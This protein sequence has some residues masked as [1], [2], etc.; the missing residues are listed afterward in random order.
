MTARR[1]GS[2]PARVAEDSER[3][4]AAPAPGR[5]PAAGTARTDPASDASDAVAACILEGYAA[6]DRDFR[7]V[8]RWARRRFEARDWRGGQA[9]AA[10]RL[11]LYGSALA[12]TLRAVDRLAGGAGA[13]DPAVWRSA[14]ARFASDA[15]SRSDSEIARTFFNSVSRR[16]FDTVGVRPELEFVGDD[17]DVPPGP[18]GRPRGSRTAGAGAGAPPGGLGDRVA[19]EVAIDADALNPIVRAMLRALPFVE[20]WG[21]LERDVFRTA[22]ALARQ[23]R[24]DR[25][26]S[27][28]VAIEVL[29]ELLYRNKAAYL[30]GRVRNG[31]QIVPLVLA[32]LHDRRGVAVD[33]VL[34]DPAEV[35]IVFGFSR[36]YFH[37]ELGAP[38]AAVE[39][40]ASI[41]PLKRAHELYTSLGYHRHGKTELYRALLR[42][43]ERPEARFEKAEGTEGTVMS[44]F[45]LPSLNV[46]FKVIKDRFPPSKR[47]TREEVQRRYRQ[48][49]VRDRV[50]RLA[51]AQE[52]EHLELRRDRFAPGLLERLLEEAGGSVHVE[53]DRVV[54]EHLYTERRMTPLDLYLERADP[55]SARTAILDYGWAVRDLAAANIFPGDLL[56]KNFGVSRHGRVIFYDYDELTGLEECRFRALPAARRPED[57][58]ADEPWF[59]VAPGDVFPEEFPRFLAIPRTLRSLFLGHHGELFEPAF[60]REMQERQRVGDVVDFFPYPEERRLEPDS[61]RRALR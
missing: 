15:A 60:W 2:S 28:T 34:T 50:G 14:R 11:G 47:V 37:A 16:V 6:Y 52:F 30:V 44:V 40:L 9:D 48:V 57:E 59:H 7:R 5:V 20:L 22:T 17:F 24:E 51:D 21:H 54:I 56:L 8:T 33:A 39:F 32:L 27:G 31:E 35:S 13:P 41:L 19:S 23:L 45:M 42:E 38:R 49:F 4:A 58:L 61:A 10:E 53:G 29:P 43:T 12:D 36:S 18:G 55:A 1:P 3:P 26:L 46:V 25:R